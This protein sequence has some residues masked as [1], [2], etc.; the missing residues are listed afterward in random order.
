MKTQAIQKAI[1]CQQ[2]TNKNS[3]TNKMIQQQNRTQNKTWT[4]KQRHC[5][6]D[7]TKNRNTE[8]TKIKWV[9][10]PV[11]KNNKQQENE[12]KKRKIAQ[13]LENS[14]THYKLELSNS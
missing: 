5:E 9:G 8:T 11:L 13:L 3:D 12:E 14:M 10:K 4:T 2:F 1:I 7:S 6:L